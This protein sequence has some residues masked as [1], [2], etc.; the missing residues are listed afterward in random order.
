MA[1]C[2][3]CFVCVRVCVCVSLGYSRS[4]G[5]WGDEGAV[6]ALRRR[7]LT[8]VCSQRPGQVMENDCACVCVCNYRYAL[9]TSQ[10]LVSYA[11]GWKICFTHQP[12]SKQ[13]K[14]KKKK[15]SLFSG[16]KKLKHWLAI[17]LLG[18]YVIFG[19]CRCMCLVRWVPQRWTQCS[20]WFVSAIV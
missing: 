6:H 3:I 16:W 13:A 5:V 12:K 11:S 4:G 7:L 9:A 18:K 10:V 20:K 14:K 2:L 19:S 15:S 8:G 1:G 17:W